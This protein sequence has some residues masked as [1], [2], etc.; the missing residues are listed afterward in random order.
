MEI[1]QFVK[2]FDK[3]GDIILD[4]ELNSITLLF[5]A[6]SAENRI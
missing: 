5:F 3:K 4:I 2:N 1:T 6:E